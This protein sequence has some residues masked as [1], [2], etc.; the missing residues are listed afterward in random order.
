MKFYF[1]QEILDIL[2]LL[3]VY[4]LLKINIISKDEGLVEVSINNFVKKKLTVG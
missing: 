1:K 2:I 4:S 3:L